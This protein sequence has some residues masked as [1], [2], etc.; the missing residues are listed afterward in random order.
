MRPTA[1]AK[2]MIAAESSCGRLAR[3]RRAR[4]ASRMLVCVS[5]VALLTGAA[6]AGA[7]PRPQPQ[8][9]PS[10][11]KLWQAFPLER[12]QSRPPPAVPRPAPTSTRA[13]TTPEQPSAD[14]GMTALE[15]VALALLGTVVAIGLAVGALVYVPRRPP[16]SLARGPAWRPAAERVSTFAT[17]TA[18]AARSRLAARPRPR[19]DF[20]IG[21]QARGAGPAV[22]VDTIQALLAASR[23]PR[24]SSRPRVSP[25]RAAA[26][27][28][29]KPESRQAGDQV[30]GPGADA[31]GAAF[32]KS[33]R[34]SSSDTAKLKA[35]L[36]SPGGSGSTRDDVDELKEKLRRSKPATPDAAAP[37]AAEPAADAGPPR[38]TELEP[39]AAQ[40]PQEL[41]SGRTSSSRLR[42]VPTP[43]TASPRR[44]PRRG[45]STCRIALWRGYIKAQFYAAAEGEEDEASAT[46][47]YFRWWKSGP[48][49]QDRDDVAAAHAS[50]LATLAA[51]GWKPVG[52]G[53]EW[54]ELK[55][56]REPRRTVPDDRAGGTDGISTE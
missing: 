34:R 30:H 6:A 51:A 15:L 3:L 20:G 43:A 36:A 45:P 26:D 56:R 35:K 38:P 39:A 23:M 25:L 50:L 8:P 17:R 28:P 5:G 22:A 27:R 24:A 44:A 10:P 16:R 52:E 54:F 32:P 14:A 1:N 41:G 21:A 37:A 33:G 40:P 7:A 9:Q 19:L 49:P 18:A 53:D 48:P 47:P 29:A 31:S 46:S 12:P 55:L 13:T 4:S 2:G 11:Q 42:P